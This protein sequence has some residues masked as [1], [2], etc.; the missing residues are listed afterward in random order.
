M[1]AFRGNR[2]LASSLL[3]SSRRTSPRL[4]EIANGFEFQN[5]N[6]QAILLH[7]RAY[8]ITAHLARLL[9]VLFAAVARASSADL[10][11][12]YVFKTQ[13][14]DVQIITQNDHSTQHSALSIQHS[15]LSTLF[16]NE[17]SSVKSTV[18]VL[19]CVLCST[20]VY[21]ELLN[22]TGTGTL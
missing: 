21:S 20:P 15:A 2:G 7:L 22:D 19:S 13:T 18:L 1:Q 9:A 17:M 12:S 6:R 16:G 11:V 4:S 8:H 3:D 5:G 14:S 10:L